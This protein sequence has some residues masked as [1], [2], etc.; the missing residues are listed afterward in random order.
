METLEIKGTSQPKIV[1]EAFLEECDGSLEHIESALTTLRQ[2]SHVLNL[3]TEI[4]RNLS[5][6]LHKL[7]GSCGFVGFLELCSLVKK[8]EH[9]FRSES[10]ELAGSLDTLTIS[11][12]ELITE[13]KSAL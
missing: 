5:Q 7:R 4:A 10:P 1:F 3:G 13:I 12:T 11:L 6:S 8:C 2:G 9:D